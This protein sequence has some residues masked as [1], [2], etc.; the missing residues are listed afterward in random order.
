MIDESGDFVGVAA[1][2]I[3]EETSIKITK[4]QLK[5]LGNYY[6]SPGGSDE[7][8]FLYYSH[9]NLSAEELK[10]VEEKIHGKEG[11]KERIRVKLIDYTPEAIL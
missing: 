5:P 6:P 4:E 8:I 10:V 11:E 1:A 2:E 7:Q 9:I 3:E